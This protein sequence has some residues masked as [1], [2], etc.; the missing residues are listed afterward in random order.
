MVKV[1]VPKE[2]R[3][4]ETRVAATPETVKHLVGDGLEIT[5]EAGAGTAA[6]FSDEAYG[7]AGALIA[8]D[9]AAAWAEADLVLKVQCPDAEEIGRLR[10]GALLIGLLSPFDNLD[11]VRQLAAGKVTSL[12]MELVPRISRAQSMDALSSQ[13]SIAGYKAVLLA[14]YRLPQYFPLLMTAAGTIPPARVVVMGAGV[15]GL[16]A[17]ATAKRLG[18]TV[19]VSDI[20]PAVKEQVESLGAKFIELPME[21][22]GEG[23]GGYAKQ[24]TEDFLTKQREIV[25]RRL[26]EADVA[27]TTALVPGKKAPMLI[28]ED[29][30]R[31]MKA[32]AVIVDLAVAQGGNCALS[33]QD[34]EVMENGVLILGPSNLPAQTMPQDASTLYARNLQ[35]LIRLMIEEGKLNLDLEDEV[36]AGSLL[37]HEGKVTNGPVAAQLEGESS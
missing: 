8:T 31:G 19:E 34:E 4:G 23:E 27:V 17:I 10:E 26:A 24:M 35:A 30:V 36:L 29:M 18:A 6:S 28:S 16:Q 7:T 33:K 2:R 3:A 25:K 37:T 1:F 22:T 11:A 5:V 21:E 13:A 20:R 14:A 9:P 12:S 32:G 15:A